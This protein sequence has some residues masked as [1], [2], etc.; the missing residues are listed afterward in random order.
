MKKKRFIK[1]NNKD[2]IELNPNN[3]IIHPINLDII[4][5]VSSKPLCITK[6]NFDNS[7]NKVNTFYNVK[8][9]NDNLNNYNNFLY[10]PPIGFSYYDVLNIYNISSS[11]SLLSFI[12]DNI[13]TMPYLS[14]NRVIN[15]WIYKNYNILKNHNKILINIFYKLILKIKYKKIY[16]M[17]DF[18]KII[19][20]HINLWI[21]KNNLNN[22]NFNLLEY[23]LKKIN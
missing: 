11:D 10:I 13:D 4:D 2:I 23:L 22:Y 12:E 16:N 20:H 5:N 17:D 18:K 3:K 19:E 8:Y 6:Y 15:S 9:N 7:T 1:S 21:N 14:I